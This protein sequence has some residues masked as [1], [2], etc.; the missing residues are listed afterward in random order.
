[1]LFFLNS[2]I[3]NSQIYGVRTCIF[4][5]LTSEESCGTVESNLRYDVMT[6]SCLLNIL[7]IRTK[8]IMRFLEGQAYIERFQFHESYNFS[9]FF[10]NSHKQS[11]AEF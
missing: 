8:D 11:L 1:M 7:N 10:P 2:G 9:Y 3:S 6:G 4:L 5:N